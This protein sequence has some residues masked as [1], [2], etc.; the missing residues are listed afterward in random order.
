MFVCLKRKI[1]EKEKG[2]N[3]KF[4]SHNTSILPVCVFSCAFSFSLSRLFLSCILLT[5]LVCFVFSGTYFVNKKN[6][7]DHL[8]ER[9]TFP[10]V[11]LWKIPEYFFCV[12]LLQWDEGKSR[13][14]KRRERTEGWSE[15]LEV[16][17]EGGKGTRE[18]EEEMHG[19]IQDG[20]TIVCCKVCMPA[21]KGVT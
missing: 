19:K 15:I 16:K 11:Y 21:Y 9:A 5:L 1:G 13:E 2:D 4:R 14:I 7:W 3:I 20:L 17:K 8:I 10:K 18:G 12:Q 6:L